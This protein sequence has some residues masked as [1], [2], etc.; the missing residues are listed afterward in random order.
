VQRVRVDPGDVGAVD[1]GGESDDVA[2]GRPEPKRARG[3]AGLAAEVG[4][5][6]RPANL[7]VGA[8]CG[9]ASRWLAANTAAMP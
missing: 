6:D 1:Q 3:E 8:S 9:M 5:V 7:L 4:D 2:R